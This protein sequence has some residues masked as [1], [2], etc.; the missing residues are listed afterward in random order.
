MDKLRANKKD[1]DTDGESQSSHPDYASSKRSRTVKDSAMSPGGEGSQRDETQ[2]QRSGPTSQRGQSLGPGEE[3]ES[4]D[5]EHS[6]EDE[7]NMGN[8]EQQSHTEMK[9]ELIDAIKEDLRIQ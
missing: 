1:G 5:E 2:G 3:E 7:D 6:S 9:Q 4:E 8:L